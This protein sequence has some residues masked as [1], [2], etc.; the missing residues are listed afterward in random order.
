MAFVEANGERPF[1]DR[2]VSMTPLYTRELPGGGFVTIE[3]RADGGEE[4]YL[5]RVWVE[6]RG[7]PKRREGHEPPVIVELAGSSAQQI[8]RELY[9]IAADNVAVARGLIQWQVRRR[10]TRAD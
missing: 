4:S 9:A 7:D 3:A 5:G 6:R 10:A 8:F 2:P 1:R